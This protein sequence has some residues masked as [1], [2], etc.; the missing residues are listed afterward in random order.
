[1]NDSEH[2]QF[3]Q[4]VRRIDP[5]AALTRVTPL[6][7][8]VSASVMALDVVWADGRVDRLVARQHGA[9]DRARK[10]QVARDEYRLLQIAHAA[11]IPVAEPLLLDETGETV[12]LPVI[13]SAFVD[14][15]TEFAPPDLDAYLEQA[16]A[17]LVSIHQ[18]PRSDAAFLPDIGFDNGASPE[19]LDEVMGE[20]RIRSALAA[21]HPA[22]WN[23]SAV[24]HGDYWP[25][26]LLWRDGRL[27]GVLDWEDVCLG[28]P[29]VEL[30]NTRLELLWA[31]GAEAMTR[32]TECYCALRPLDLT[33]LPY[34]D[35]RA[36][37]RSCGTLL[38]WG[39]E[40]ETERRM[41]ERH[42]SFVESAVAAIERRSCLCL[43]PHCS[44][45]DLVDP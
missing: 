35:L 33:L 37:L 18:L 44:R 7:G 9:V 34:W 27:V 17:R 43:P 19:D 30:G 41:I 31:F 16:A 40:P 38:T 39:L 12:P 28:D 29:L 15:A 32:F 11:G 6:P 1:M 45:Y 10:P 21:F 5:K 23:E 20:G 13:V 8:G 36:A 14:G 2:E 42:A 26:N 3:V 25:G 22:Q 4:L 24:L